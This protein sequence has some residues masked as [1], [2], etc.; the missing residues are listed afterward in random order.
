MFKIIGAADAAANL[1]WEFKIAAKKEAM[2]MKNKKGKVI[3]VRFI[4]IFIFSK[5]PAKPGAI[6]DTNPGIKIWTKSTKKSKPK[7]KRLKMLLAK[8]FD[9]FVP[10]VISEE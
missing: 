9:C 8:S 1:L 3:L 10:F 5:S 2:L 6:I 4:A 7:N